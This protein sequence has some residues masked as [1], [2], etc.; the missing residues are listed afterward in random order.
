MHTEPDIILTEMALSQRYIQ[1]HPWVITAVNG[2]LSAYFMEQPCFRVQRH[3]DEVESGAHVWLC[4]VPATMKMATL[5]RRLQADIPSCRYS[6]VP[7]GQNTYPRYVI[8][9][10]SS[11]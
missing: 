4:E 7:P 6:L 2:F 9:V 8:D 1:D 11:N 3:F 10:P 5:L